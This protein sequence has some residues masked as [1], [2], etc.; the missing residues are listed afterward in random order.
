[1]RRKDKE[2][3]EREFMDSVISRSQVCRIGLCLEGT[4]YIVPMCFGYDSGTIYLHSAKE[5]RKIDILKKNPA[6]CFEFDIDCELK[7]G[8]KPCSFS[9]KY[10]S[11]MGSGE[12]S[13]VEEAEAKHMALNVI[14]KHYGQGTCT[15]PEEALG[16]IVIIKIAIKEITAK[17]SGY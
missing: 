6:V 14:M 17:K 11:V 15:F 8:D 13:F 10:R 4:P 1:M 12:A 2:V 3:V 7:K 16:N 5:G 9:M